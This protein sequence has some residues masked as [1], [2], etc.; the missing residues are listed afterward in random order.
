MDERVP[1]W[2]RTEPLSV[3]SPQTIW[4]ERKI[5]VWSLRLLKQKEPSLECR[6]LR[7]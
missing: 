2:I 5:G 4:P 3:L 1:K 6:S 7:S